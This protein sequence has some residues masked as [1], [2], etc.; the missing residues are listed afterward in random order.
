VTFERELE[1]AVAATREASDLLRTKFH[2]VRSI[3]LKGIADLVTDADHASEAL[4]ADRLLTTFPD[5]EFF[6]E[7]GT[8]RAAT[9]N[10]RRWLVDPLDGTTN[11]AHGYPI[12][13]VSVALEV[14]GVVEIGVVAMPMLDELYV[15]RRGAGATLNDCPLRVSD[16]DRLADAVVGTGF[17]YNLERRRA[18]LAHWALFVERSQAARRDGAAAFDLCCVAAGRFDGFWEHSL[19]PWDV[20]AGT[21]I[22]TEAGATV[23]NYTGEPFDLYAGEVVASNRLI[24]AEMLATIAEADARSHS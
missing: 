16:V 12:F 8:N 19:S 13:A 20:A 10:R 1:I 6:G 2:E 22:A 3:T 18:N 5:D 17:A 7:E 21:L 11:Y 14:A 15:A 9:R 4:L 23:T 24:H